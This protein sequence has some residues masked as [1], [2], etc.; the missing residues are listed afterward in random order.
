MDFLGTLFNHDHVKEVKNPAKFHRVDK[1]A[2]NIFYQLAHCDSL[3]LSA[4]I[5]RK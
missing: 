1:T 3:Q 5:H 2:K 4:Y